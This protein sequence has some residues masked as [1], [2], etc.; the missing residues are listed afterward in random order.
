MIFEELGPTFIKFGQIL[1]IR[2]D[3]LP[4]EYVEEFEKLQDA[5][6]PFP[7]LEVM[8]LVH[9]EFSSAAGLTAAPA[10]SG[11]EDSTKVSVRPGFTAREA[12]LTRYP[13]FSGSVDEAGVDVSPSWL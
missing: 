4:A 12:P 5:V 1:S 7:F 8:R 6:P 13:G 2:R 11:S 10:C 3:L 9:E